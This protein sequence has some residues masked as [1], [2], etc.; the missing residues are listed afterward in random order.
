MEWLATILNGS[1]GLALIILVALVIGLI[2]RGIKKGTF[3]FNGHGVTIGQTRENELRIVREQLQHMERIADATINDIPAHLR[4]GLHYYRA[5]Y[6]ISKFKDFMEVL[7][8]Y[9]HITKDETYVS[10]KQQ[11]AYALVMKITDDEFFK[12]EEFKA[13]M[14]KLVKDIICS[15]VDVRLAYSKMEL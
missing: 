7:I 3:S 1:N 14:F 2:Y 4:E 12:T 10:L 6:V 11:E 9:N 5:K 15:L 13:Y 8:I